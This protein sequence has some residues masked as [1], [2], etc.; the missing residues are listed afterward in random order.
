M[1]EEF[2]ITLNKFWFLEESYNLLYTDLD[3]E[4]QKKSNETCIFG[5]GGSNMITKI[6]FFLNAE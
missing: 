2:I 3:R 4:L 1:L 6:F 5:H